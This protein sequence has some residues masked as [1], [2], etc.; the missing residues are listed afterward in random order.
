MGALAPAPDLAAAEIVGT[1]MDRQEWLAKRR[2]GLGGSD[3]AALLGISR[4]HSPLSLWL[5]K[6]GELDEQQERVTS[7]Q[8]WGLELEDPIRR[9]YTRKTGVGV[10]QLPEY[11]MYRSRELPI[12]LVTPDGYADDGGGF[13]AK[14]SSQFMA[15]EWQDEHGRPVL[16]AYYEAQ[17]QWESAVTGWDHVHFGVLIGASDFRTMTVVADKELHEQ[18]YERAREFWTLVEQN[19]MPDVDGTTASAKALAERYPHAKEGKRVEVGPNL[20]QLVSQ[21]KSLTDYR[22][23]AE[24]AEREV[25]NKIKLLLGDAEVGLCDGLPVVTWKSQSRKS[26]SVESLIERY[27]DLAPELVRQSEFRVLRA[28]K[29]WK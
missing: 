14:T 3:I 13:E 18:L 2:Q 12:A 27:P 16:P 7:A 4:W 22:K 20:T 8:E 9:A 17:A 26:V 25:E 28:K 19:K 11:T 5:E 21:W 6:R 29:G 23:A 15:D 24:T 1:G 10:Y